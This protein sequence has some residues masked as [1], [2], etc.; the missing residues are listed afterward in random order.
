MFKVFHEPFGL[1]TVMDVQYSRSLVACQLM[2]RKKYKNN[3][4]KSGFLQGV[5]SQCMVVPEGGA[6]DM[7]VWRARA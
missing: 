4:L 5:R 7:Y 3:I 6:V 1:C 2:T